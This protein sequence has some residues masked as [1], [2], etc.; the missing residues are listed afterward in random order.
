MYHRGRFAIFSNDR[1]SFQWHRSIAQDPYTCSDCNSD[2]INQKMGS[3][4]KIFNYMSWLCHN[5]SNDCHSDLISPE[6]GSQWKVSHYL[7][8]AFHK[9]LVDCNRD[10]S[11]PETGSW[12]QVFNYLQGHVECILQPSVCFLVICSIFGL[13]SRQPTLSFR[14]SQI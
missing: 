2:L 3:Q 9:V 5:V 7:L 14:G 10:L 1:R 13:R 6:M 12:C 11:N 8:Q 4:H